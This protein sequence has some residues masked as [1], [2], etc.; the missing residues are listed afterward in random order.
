VC[1]PVTLFCALIAKL[2]SKQNR[3]SGFRLILTIFTMIQEV[4]AGRKKKSSAPTL[5]AS[6]AALGRVL[7]EKE[8][9]TPVLKLRFKAIFD[10]YEKLVKLSST[11]L[12]S[13]YELN[14]NS[15][16]D[17]HAD[18][19]QNDATV[20]HV[21]SFSP[22]ELVGTAILIAMHMDKRSDDELIEDIKGMRH[23]IR[24]KHKDLRVNAQC[25]ATTWGF[26]STELPP[27]WSSQNDTPEASDVNNDNTADV[28][29]GKADGSSVSTTQSKSTGDAEGGGGRLS[30]VLLTRPNLESEVA[31]SPNKTRSAAGVGGGGNLVSTAPS[32]HSGD[33]KRGYAAIPANRQQRAKHDAPLQSKSK[34]GNDRK[35]GGSTPQK[36]LKLVSG[37]MNGAAGTP[38]H[39]D[40]MVGGSSPSSARGSKRTSN[41]EDRGTRAPKKLKTASDTGGGLGESS[42]KSR[43]G[44]GMGGGTASSPPKK[45]KH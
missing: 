40:S 2:V 21:Q 3:G 15:A 16:F 1:P 26:I 35:D 18:F 39:T 44:N 41:T 14:R 36:G 27:R 30:T 43:R 23:Y 32:K 5:Q 22:L 24:V 29:N 12:H 28:K 31:K 10:R 34:L 4:L 19:L 9:V 11:L 45:S 13:K 7:D 25:W 33:G 17:P 37:A 38:E 20:S 42:K 6:P 8:K